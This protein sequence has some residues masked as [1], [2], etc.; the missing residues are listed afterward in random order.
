MDKFHLIHQ[1]LLHHQ[2]TNLQQIL[3]RK[4]LYQHLPYLNQQLQVYHL[5]LLLL[6]EE[7]FFGENQLHPSKIHRQIQILLQEIDLKKYLKFYLYDMQVIAP[8]N[9]KL[10]KDFFERFD[11]NGYLQSNLSIQKTVQ[12]EIFLKLP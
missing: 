7:C 2:Q 1:K 5:H 11:L 8:L 10:S 12:F 6:Q 3:N 9:Q 4:E